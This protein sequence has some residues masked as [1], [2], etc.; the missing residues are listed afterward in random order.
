MIIAILASLSGRIGG[1]QEIGNRMGMLRVGVIGTGSFA[2]VCHIPG[3]QSHPQAKVVALCGRRMDRTRLLAERLNVP[4]VYTDYYDLCA[5]TDIDAV[6]IATPNVAHAQ[7]AL[8]ALAAGKHVLCEKPLAMNVAEAVEMVCA[9]VA[10]QKVHQVAFTFRY[11]LGVQ[12]LRRRLRRGDIG[13]PYHIRLH[14]ETWEGFQPNATVGFR[15]KADLAGGGMLYDVGAHLFDM[16]SFL[17]GPIEAVT[18]FTQLIPRERPDQSTGM[19][20]AVDTDDIAAAWFLC[21]NGV[22]GQWFASRATPC[23]GDKAYV[24]VIGREGA[25]RASLS[26]GSIDTLRISRPASPLWEILPLPEPASDGRPHCLGRMMRSFVDACLRGKLDDEID[27]SFH[28]GLA[29][30][31]ALD[32]VGVASSR[33]EWVSV[34]GGRRKGLHREFQANPYLL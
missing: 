22:Q 14:F 11:L 31:R 23:S 10:S 32:A 27:A 17:L 1:L 2:E 13:E 19:L 16:A 18:G 3:L 12:E 20:T 8:A 34:S 33:H 7:Q 5:R 26:R 4:D 24:E 25:M 29:A 21:T 6:T 30:Q 9:A 28:D 15:E